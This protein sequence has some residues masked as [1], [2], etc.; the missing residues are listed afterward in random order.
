MVMSTLENQ[1]FTRVA[2]LAHTPSVIGNTVAHGAGEGILAVFL[3]GTDIKRN[4]SMQIHL[5][6]FDVVTLPFLALHGLLN[7]RSDVTKEMLF[8][9][10]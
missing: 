5:G 4:R 8:F 3:C 2:Q 9:N 1:V 6:A 7:P 10:R